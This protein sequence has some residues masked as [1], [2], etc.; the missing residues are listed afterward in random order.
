MFLEQELMNAQI[1]VLSVWQEGT[2]GRPFSRGRKHC[3]QQ[4]GFGLVNKTALK[5]NCRNVDRYLRRVDADAS[6][7]VAFRP[8][9]LL[10]G[11]ARMRW[12]R[13]QRHCATKAYRCPKKKGYREDCESEFCFRAHGALHRT[14]LHAPSVVSPN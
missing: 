6:H 14:S 10:F 4:T 12:S 1:A 13:L 9:S 8:R 11:A 3:S 5:I 2:V 7:V